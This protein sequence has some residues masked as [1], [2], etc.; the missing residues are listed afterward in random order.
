M[1]SCVGVPRS[2]LRKVLEVFDRAQGVGEYGDDEYH[3][4]YPHNPE[5][6]EDALLPEALSL[7]HVASGGGCRM[8]RLKRVLVAVTVNCK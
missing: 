7:F 5:G 8:G 1:S 3:E 6:H 4:T 2:W